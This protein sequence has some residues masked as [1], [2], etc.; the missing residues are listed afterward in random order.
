[1]EPTDILFSP[2][3]EWPHIIQENE[4]LIS[5]NRTDKIIELLRHLPYLDSRRNQ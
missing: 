4:V 5:L 3:G 1:M 2:P